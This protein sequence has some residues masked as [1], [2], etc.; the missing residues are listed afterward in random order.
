VRE[1]KSGFPRGAFYT[2][3]NDV[4]M[5]AALVAHVRKSL[6]LESLREL[7]EEIGLTPEDTSCFSLLLEM[8]VLAPRLGDSRL[9]EE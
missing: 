8:N 2:S 6:P 9:L 1:A 4:T 3:Q 5:E 7:A